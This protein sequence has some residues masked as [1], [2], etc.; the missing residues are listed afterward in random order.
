MT[1]R[2]RAVRRDTLGAI[3]QPFVFLAAQLAA[4]AKHAAPVPPGGPLAPAAELTEHVQ[5]GGVA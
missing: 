3:L 2:H 4:V 1:G 5:Q